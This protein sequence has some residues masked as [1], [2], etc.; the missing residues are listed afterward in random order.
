MSSST[1]A[2][3][4]LSLSRAQLLKTPSLDTVLLTPPGT[5]PANL[6]TT[7][8]DHELGTAITMSRRPSTQLLP[9]VVLQRSPPPNLPPPPDLP[10]VEDG[11]LVQALAAVGGQVL[12]TTLLYPLAVLKTR[13]QT[14]GVGAAIGDASADT[15]MSGMVRD[16][17]ARDGVAGLYHG[18]GGEMIKE[19]FNRFIYF[20]IYA[21]CKRKLL[22]RAAADDA[23][24]APDPG[25]GTDPDPAKSVP[26]PRLPRPPRPPPT[27]SVGM[28][29]LA[30]M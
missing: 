26:P 16:I 28:N 22:A 23:A 19:S 21:F 29:I 3:L 1:R 11:S 9:G 8:T 27:L 17:M 15:S 13:A 20:Y 2:D 4:D 14:A 5:P 24:A 7:V 18:M 12:S 25:P 6:A 10:P 30:G